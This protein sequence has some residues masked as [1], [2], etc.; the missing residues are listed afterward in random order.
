MNQSP[1]NQPTAKSVK[2]SPNSRSLAWVF[3][4]ITFLTIC[5]CGALLAVWVGG[6]SGKEGFLVGLLL[7]FIPVPFYV[8][9]VLWIDRYEPEPA[10]MLGAAF[11]WGAVISTAFASIINSAGG[12]MVGL[13]AGLEA[14][15]IF[16][17]VIS[18]PIVEETIKGVAV[19]IF[20]LWRRDEFDNIIDGILYAALIGLGFAMTEN[21]I[22]YGRA[23]AEEGIAGSASLFILRGLATPFIHPLCTAMT[24]IG[25]GI[26]R[27]R[28]LSAVRYFSPILGLFFAITLH[29]IWNLSA[30]LGG[31]MIAYVVVLIPTLIGVLILIQVVQRKEAKILKEFLASDFQAG[32]F[33]QVEYEA[34]CSMR[35]RSNVLWK[36]LTQG[37]LKEW[38]NALQFFQIAGELAFHRWR[39]ARFIIP[40]DENSRLKEQEYL[41][42]LGRG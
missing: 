25:F 37:G 2:P 5:C 16:T 30:T 6:E 15:D 29:G 41:T 10:W 19:L 17:S 8:L 21:V 28:N 42:A 4:L 34:M 35:K 32:R 38:Q 14:G 7:A 11:V 33:S 24:G 26:A 23:F 40:Y 39:V 27:Q 18:A 20:F 9:L 1:N 22:Y 13:L 36:M 3:G 31:W 12:L